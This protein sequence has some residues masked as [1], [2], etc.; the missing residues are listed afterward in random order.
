M[1]LETQITA[2]ATAIGADVKAL[3][4]LSGT[5]TLNFGANGNDMASVTVAAASVT[6]ASQ[7]QVSLSPAGTADNDADEH[8]AEPAQARITAIVPGVSFDISMASTDQTKLFGTWLV[9][10]SIL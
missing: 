8:F 9:N 5:A 7:V 4:A 6:A 3:K 10:W 1:S 2:L